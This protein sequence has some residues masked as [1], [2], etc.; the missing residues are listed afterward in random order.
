MSQT[1]R[2]YPNTVG[3]VWGEWT[4][5]EEIG[6][7]EN[8]HLYVKAKCSC[9]TVKEVPYSRLKRGKSK[10]CGKC[11]S[12]EDLTGKKFHRWTVLKKADKNE[13][14]NQ[15]YFC[16]CDCG[17]ERVISAYKLKHGL[18]HSCGCYISDSVRKRMTTHS[19]SKTKIFKEWEHMRRRCLPN[20]ECHSR[21][22]DRGIKVCSEWENSFEKF[23]EY[24]S[25]LEHYGDR[26][27][28]LDRIDNNGNY[29]PSNVRWASPKT[30][31]R[32]TEKN[33]YITYKGEQRLLC[34]LV[35][36][37][38]YNYQ[39]IYG[40]LQRGWSGDEA[41]DTP[42]NKRYIGSRKTSF[43]DAKKEV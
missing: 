24:V 28:S 19:M 26:N 13:N 10:S 1:R 41:I 21:Y 11:H 4:I 33:V 37:R 35:E 14:S 15:W 39:T 32:N 2:I 9:G 17:T 20:A 31:A 43:F 8:G 29:E 18:T 36:E 25:Q 7:R 16:K 22:Y 12:K 40:R 27:Y 34:E 23:Y 30:Q 3:E 42:I 5:L 6:Y 38:G